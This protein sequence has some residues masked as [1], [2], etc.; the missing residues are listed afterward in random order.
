MTAKTCSQIHS[1]ARVVGFR[2]GVLWGILGAQTQLL[3]LR[4][5]RTSKCILHLHYRVLT[6]TVVL[7][8]KSF[9]LASKWPLLLKVSDLLNKKFL[10]FDNNHLLSLKV[11]KV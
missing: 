3:R 7:S 11:E 8:G 10:I 5:T 2:G 6:K 4:Y 1:V 9:K